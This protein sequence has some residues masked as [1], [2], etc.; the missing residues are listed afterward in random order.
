MWLLILLF[1]IAKLLVFHRMKKQQE[2][3]LLDWVCPKGYYGLAPDPVDCNSFYACPDKIQF[4]CPPNMQFDID[5]QNC[6]G[7]EYENGCFAVLE[8]NL[9]L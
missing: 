4:F 5:S 8:R 9:L 1:I 2:N 6:V 3:I 7:L